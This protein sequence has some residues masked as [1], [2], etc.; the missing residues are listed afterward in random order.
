LKTCCTSSRFDA[1]S[2]ERMVSASGETEVTA[3]IVSQT[4]PSRRG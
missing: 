2:S 3:R 1:S 4:T